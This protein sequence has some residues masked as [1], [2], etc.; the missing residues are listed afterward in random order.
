MQ[1][2]QNDKQYNPYTNHSN[3][4]YQADEIIPQNNQT[5]NKK[6]KKK[7]IWG[8]ILVSGIS[9]LLTASIFIVYIASGLSQSLN[10]VYIDSD[11]GIFKE[12]N[13]DSDISADS[14]NSAMKK[15]NTIRDLI[16]DNYYEKLSKNEIIEAMTLG[17]LENLGS[18]YTFYLSPEEVEQMEDSM[19]GAYSGIGATVEKVDDHYQVSDLVEDSPADKAGI[20]INDIFVSIDGYSADGYEDVSALAAD[21]RGEKGT[22]VEI[23]ILRPSENKRYTFTVERKEITNSNIHAKMLDDNIGYVRITSFND[24]VSDN[25]IEAMDQL[26]KEGAKNVIFDLR[27]NGGGYVDEVLDMLDYLLPEGLLITEVGRR[28]GK[29]FEVEEYSDE[30][31]GVPEDMKYVCLINQNSASASE[32]FSGCLR[33]W[34]KA[35]L[36]G[37]KSFGKGVGTITKFLNDGSAVQITNFYY[38]LPNGENIDG[39]GL[40]P[41]Y[42]VELPEDVKNVIVSRINLE[43]DLQL[44]KAIEILEKD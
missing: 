1:E 27:N 30:Y 23:Q 25:F 10:Q 38:N 15:F 14:D 29:D 31:M 22:T 41:D 2:N 11:N 9:I 34:E 6:E 39:E 3:N 28:D 36:V 32:L 33:D 40:E 37:E 7:D 13:I 16:L 44:K 5:P 42:L 8:Y 43:Q 12:E 17:M 35:Q 21:I 26:Q 20:L 4:Y 18:P 19:S 24:G